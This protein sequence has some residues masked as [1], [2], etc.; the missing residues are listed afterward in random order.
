MTIDYSVT[1]MVLSIRFKRPGAYQRLKQGTVRR[2]E[3]IAA[4]GGI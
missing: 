3:S 1:M 4:A 2:T